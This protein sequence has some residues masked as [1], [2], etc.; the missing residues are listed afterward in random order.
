MKWCAIKV[1]ESTVFALI[2]RLK[3][4]RTILAKWTGA[5]SRVAVTNEKKEMPLEP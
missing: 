2:N 3:T 1:Q 4:H 5:L